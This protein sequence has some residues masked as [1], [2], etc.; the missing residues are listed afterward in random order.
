[1]YSAQIAFDPLQA[2]QM[3]D[4][5]DIKAKF[6]S[7]GWTS[8]KCEL[9][10]IWYKRFLSI[11]AKYPNETIAPY[12]PIDDFWH[13]HILDTRRYAK[14]CEKV[15]GRFLHHLPTYGNYDISETLDKMNRL[16]LI[17]FGEDP[18]V[19]LG[20]YE[21]ALSECHCDDSGGQS[22]QT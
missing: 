16:Y 22:D 21:M 7:K 19:E 13:A 11:K 15:F 10:E 12:G 17:E 8:R 1:M 14:D 20:D 6:V 3:L 5:T 2:I 9:V 18:V 4:F